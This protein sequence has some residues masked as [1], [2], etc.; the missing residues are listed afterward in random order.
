MKNVTLS[1]PDDILRRSREY[2]K[3]HGLT[4]NQM[5]RNLLKQTISDKNEDLTSRL[6]QIIDTMGV[7]T[8]KMKEHSREDLYERPPTSKLKINCPFGTV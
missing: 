8:R 2:A 1:I 5:I 7:D 3:K 6:D 4:F